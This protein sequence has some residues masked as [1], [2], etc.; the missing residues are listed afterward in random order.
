MEDIPEDRPVYLNCKT[1]QTIYNAVLAL[2]GKGFRNVYNISGGF[3]GLCFFE[4]FND[5]TKN[6]EPI[7][8]AYSFE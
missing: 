3:L 8:T 2:Q 4:Y 7:V 5:R 6:R 1:G